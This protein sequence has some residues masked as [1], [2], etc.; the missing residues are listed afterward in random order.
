MDTSFES[1]C[2]ALLTRT[3]SPEEIQGWGTVIKEPQRCRSWRHG[4]S[5]QVL[6][7]CPLFALV[8][9]EAKLLGLMLRRWWLHASKIL[10][11]PTCPLQYP[12]S[13]PWKSPQD[14]PSRGRSLVQ[15]RHVRSFTTPPFRPDIVE[16]LL[17]TGG[18]CHRE[19]SLYI[20]I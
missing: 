3:Y 16:D 20:Y 14:S 18:L 6:V 4:R 11:A 2:T 19:G 1:L 9:P 10:A 17:D 13:P 15:T 12:R 7:V 8:C 5:R